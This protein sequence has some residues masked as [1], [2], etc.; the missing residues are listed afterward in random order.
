MSEKNTD[1]LEHELHAVD[2][3]KKFDAENEENFR[4]YTLAEYLQK[5]LDEKNLVKAQV[6]KDSCL[7]EIYAYRIFSGDRKNTSR[8]NILSLAVAM[9][10]SPKETDYLLYYAGHKKLYV[11]DQWDHIIWYALKNGNSILETNELLTDMN[12]SPLLGKLD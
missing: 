5:L 9:K 3:I 11:R 10:L 12:L 6:I 2:D 1:E 8:K 4:K 7:D